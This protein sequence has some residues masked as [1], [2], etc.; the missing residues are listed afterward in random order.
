MLSLFVRR[1]GGFA[2]SLQAL[3]GNVAPS[4]YAGGAP[5]V[6]LAKNATEQYITF[7]LIAPQA[8]TVKFTVIYAPSASNGGDMVFE[9]DYVKTTAGGDPSGAITTQSSFTFTPGTGAT[10]KSVTHATLQFSVAAGDHLFVKL[11]RKN[12]GSDTHT[13][14]ANVLGI[15][16]ELV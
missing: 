3:N 6:P 16:A 12:S 4:A 9:A 13:G 11:S 8:G 10:L 2:Q 1:H 14:S 15:R 5:Y 7:D